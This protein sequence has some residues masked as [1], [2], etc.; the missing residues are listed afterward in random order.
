MTSQLTNHR[1]RV[2]A[3]VSDS[4]A[5]C[6]SPLHLHGADFRAGLWLYEHDMLGLVG[7]G[8]YPLT[9]PDELDLD[10]ILDTLGDSGLELSTDAARGAHMA[11]SD[12]GKLTIWWADADDSV[13]NPGWAWRLVERDQDGVC[14]GEHSDGID[15]L[16]ELRDLL[17]GLGAEFGAEFAAEGG[18]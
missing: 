14:V 1:A 8:F 11:S 16:A 5:T 3:K 7:L 12:S 13:G 6:E 9:N 15:S 17:R 2:L 10:A 18:Q 4:G